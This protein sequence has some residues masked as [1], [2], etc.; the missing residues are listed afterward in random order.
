[1]DP[2][3]SCLWFLCGPIRSAAL[4]TETK[5]PNASSAK[6]L[7]LHENLS[8]EV[9]SEDEIFKRSDADDRLKLMTAILHCA[10]LGG[11][12]LPIH[13]AAEWGRR[14][15][16]EFNNQAI[17]ERDLGLPQSYVVDPSEVDIINGQMFFISNI[18]LPLWEPFAK[19]FPQLSFAVTNME[20]NL[21]YYTNKLEEI[22]AQRKDC[23]AEAAAESD[24]ETAA[25]VDESPAADES[26]ADAA[27]EPVAESENNANAAASTSDPV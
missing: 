13:I 18:V 23:A 14:V 1:M 25:A 26:A 9:N 2:L 10:D 16:K 12:V 21:Q 15:N 27:T 4:A 22:K 19:L 17:A 11:Q 6:E 5:S 24:A 3:I 8:A 20:N 7:R